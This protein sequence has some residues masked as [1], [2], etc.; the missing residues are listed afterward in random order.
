MRNIWTLLLMVIAA[1][2]GL[3]LGWIS[4]RNSASAGASASAPQSSYQLFDNGSQG[5]LNDV[6]N[7]ISNAYVDPV[8]K[9]S[10]EDIAI[11]QLLKQLDPHSVY[12]P[13]SDVERVSGELKSDF[14]GIG[15]MFN[16][17]DDTVMVVS[18]IAGGPSSAIGVLP[19]DKIIAV[20]GNN[21]AGK[22]A[23][24]T[25]QKVLDNLRGEI[26]TMVKI[27]V[28]RGDNAKLD[29][30]IVRGEIPLYSVVSTYQ[31]APHVGYIK[32]DRFAEKTYNEM[33]S[34]IGKLK[35]QGCDK[36]IVDLRSNSGGF[37]NVV[38]AMCNEFLKAD[39]MIVYTEGSHHDRQVS[40]ANGTGTC[41]D[42]GIV[43]LI[44]EFSAS[45]SEIF[46]GAIQDN[47]RG[48]VVGRRSFGKGL[49]QT[50]FQLSDGSNLRLTISRYHT[51]SGRCIQRPY[52]NGDEEYYDDINE[53]LRDG[54]LFDAERI[55]AD[56]ANVYYTLKKHRKVYGGGGIVPDIFVPYDSAHASRYLYTLRSKRLIYDYALAYADAHRAE[57]TGLDLN[58]LANK[59]IATP[60]IDQ[61]HD[62]A[63]K[64]GV[65]KPSTFDKSEA[66]II[67]N[68]VRA[69][70]ARSFSD[71]NDGLY[72]ILNIMDPAVDEAL[73]VFG[74]K[75]FYK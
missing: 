16:I 73:A 1:L 13:R 29:F 14:G 59:L 40:K 46:A 47:D 61:I 9:D 12:I 65:A 34:S 66:R 5:K 51:P 48:T 75:P 20:N 56:T 53:R 67:E 18:V 15:V 63:A 72:M 45:A 30:D 17:K 10:L 54:E 36:L 49:V 44:D 6:L 35:A 38:M 24:V 25:N 70:I 55:K 3:Y 42:M 4:G 33:I 71:A 7:L 52:D 2:G 74:E 21:F 27:T 69:Y 62:Y 64:R 39:E 68:E 57:L 28:L 32:I 41:Q 8:D 37:L 11:P 19:G 22:E 58:Q 43:V 26:G 60:F 23:G 31:I 50:E